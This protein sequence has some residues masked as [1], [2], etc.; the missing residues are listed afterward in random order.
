M[1]GHGNTTDSKYLNLISWISVVLLTLAQ[2][3]LMFYKISER[4]TP[5]T[6]SENPMWF[7]HPVAARS[8]DSVPSM[9]YSPTSCDALIVGFIM[10]DTKN[11]NN[12]RTLRDL[13]RGFLDIDITMMFPIGRSNSDSLDADI[14]HEALFFDDIV[15][16]DFDAD[17]DTSGNQSLLLALD[18]FMNGCANGTFFVKFTSD[19][20]VNWRALA[21]TLKEATLSGFFEFNGITWDALQTPLLMGR[22]PRETTEDGIIQSAENGHFAIL[23]RKMVKCL[24]DRM[25]RSPTQSTADDANLI[26]RFLQKTSTKAKDVDIQVVDFSGLYVDAYEIYT[27][28]KEDGNRLDCFNWWWGTSIISEKVQQT[29]W[30]IFN[31]CAY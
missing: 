4:E 13:Y 31:T 17:K 15:I 14:Y 25:L 27:G 23:N 5:L 29:F 10:T 20:L 18:Y 2:T 1:S 3:V 16:G 28:Y 22:F 6:Q 9:L 30:D 26:S 24:K 8:G 12:R 11:A 21:L 19:V 7:R